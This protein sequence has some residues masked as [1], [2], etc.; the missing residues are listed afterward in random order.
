MF[1]SIVLH[2][3]LLHLIHS[4]HDMCL[5]RGQPP[6]MRCTQNWHILCNIQCIEL[7]T[8]RCAAQLLN[9]SKP[10]M[11]STKHTVLHRKQDHRKVQVPD[12]DVQMPVRLEVQVQQCCAVITPARCCL[13]ADAQLATSASYACILAATAQ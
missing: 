6:L 3:M 13:A 5:Q 8:C 1:A 2:R 7:R 12:A 4:P 9:L 11:P 10:E